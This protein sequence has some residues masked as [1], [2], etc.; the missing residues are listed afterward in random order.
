ML[1]N[2]FHFKVLETYLPSI[3]KHSRSLIT[4]L[5]TVSDNGNK[6]IAD[7]ESYITLCAL[8]VVGGKYYDFLFSSKV[9]QVFILSNVT[10][11]TVPRNYVWDFVQEQQKTALK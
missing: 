2:T 3:N 6:S 11:T 4:K 1:T 10:L 5:I 8:D 7:I 9:D